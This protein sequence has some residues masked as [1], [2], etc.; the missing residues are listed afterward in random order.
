M[1][2]GLRVP[3]VRRAQFFLSLLQEFLFSL[4]RVSQ[5]LSS[6]PR[7]VAN[8][9]H[10]V[11][12][13][14]EAASLCL[15]DARRLENASPMRASVNVLPLFVLQTVSGGTETHRKVLSCICLVVVLVTTGT[16][17]FFQDSHI[18]P[19]LIFN[20]A[21]RSEVDSLPRFALQRKLVP[22]FIDNAIQSRADLIELEDK[23]VRF[24]DSIDS[25]LTAC[26]MIKDAADALPEFLARNH[27]AGVDHFV[28]IDDGEVDNF[29]YLHEVL[30]PMRNRV[31]LVRSN[32]QPSEKSYGYWAASSQ[33]SADLE[34]AAYVQHATKWIAFVDVDEFFEANT[35]ELYDLDYR[36]RTKF[37]HQFLQ[38]KEHRP[39]VYVRWKT[40]LT[41]GKVDPAPCGETLASYYPLV[42][43][44]TANDGHPLTRR[45]TVAQSKFLDITGTNLDD[46]FA[47]TGF[48]FHSPFNNLNS[49]NEPAPK[50]I[51]IIHYWSMS[52]VDYVRKMGRGRPRRSTEQRTMFDLLLREFLCNATVVDRSS[53]LRDDV[54]RESISRVGY[55]CQD[56]LVPVHPLFNEEHFVRNENSAIK[57]MMSRIVRGERFNAS[58]Y[59]AA[60]LLEYKAVYAGFLSRLDL[61]PWIHYYF[62]GF[63]A[64][65]PEQWFNP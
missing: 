2:R 6:E 36:P 63:G 7:S 20:E 56:I 33:I 11:L 53:S 15:A 42:C 52:V 16:F 4:S 45:K 3:I 65:S 19:K 50:E 35:P 13:W 58:K 46:S 18:S 1:V 38:Q 55:H 28:F 10:F 24:D 57:F 44:I 26:V 17:V 39:A 31:T 43:N 32:R 49:I 5:Y 25:Y 29:E 47:H 37:L 23:E 27:L 8:Q 12:C 54:V 59:S 14:Q 21:K 62:H 40:V 64:A 48:Q 30:R 60:F 34:C 61:V 22:D 41:N 9:H 51:S